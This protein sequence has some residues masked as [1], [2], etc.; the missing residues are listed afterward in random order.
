MNRL[1]E[2]MVIVDPN[3]E[4]NAILE[5]RSLGITTIALIDSNCDPDLVDLPIPGND[6]GIRSVEL[7]MSH[8]ADAVV[9]GKKNI[10]VKNEGKD[11]KRGRGKPVQQPRPMVK[12]AAQIAKEK[13]MAEAGLSRDQ[14]QGT[15]RDGRVMKDD[16][17][18]A[19]AGGAAPSSAAVPQA[20]REERVKMT[21]LRQT[22]ARRLKEAQD[23]AAM[24]TT[25]NEVD[26]TEVMALRGEYKDC[27]RKNTASNLASCRSS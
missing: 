1:P 15:G 22:I 23:T 25:F 2:C 16:V 9:A 20:E 7:I 5:A 13:A 18:R 21:R 6:D 12:S 8:L 11:G 27:S 19:A 3:K 17:A 10:V 24:L 14:V 4:K 26:M